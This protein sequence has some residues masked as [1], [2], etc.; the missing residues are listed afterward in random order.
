VRASEHWRRLA[1]EFKL[2]GGQRQPDNA[3]RLPG[4]VCS[5]QLQLDRRHSRLVQE[6]LSWAGEVIGFLYGV[7]ACLGKKGLVEERDPC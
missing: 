1:R 4:G 6:L 7:N 5:A 3:V 2:P